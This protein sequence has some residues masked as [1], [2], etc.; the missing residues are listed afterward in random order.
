MALG[1]QSTPGEAAAD[2]GAATHG[3][4]RRLVWIVGVTLLAIFVWSRSLLLTS[5]AVDANEYL[6]VV[7]AI[8]RLEHCGLS[9]EVVVLRHFANY[10]T[11]DNWWNTYLGH[12]DAYAASNLPLGVV[13]LYPPFFDAAVDDTERAVILLH[14]AQHLLGSGEEAALER[15][16]REKARLGCTVPLSVWTTSCGGLSGVPLSIRFANS[17]SRTTE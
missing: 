3:V 16:W 15:V 13:T 7:E 11:T 17:R 2:D 8:V 12:H 4:T 9:R 14:E 6:R 1:D 10:R 5:K